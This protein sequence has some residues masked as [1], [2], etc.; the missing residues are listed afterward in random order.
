ME[1]IREFAEQFFRKL[2]CEVIFSGDL[3]TVRN[4]PEKFENFVGKR[5]PFVFSFGEAI[6]GA[7]V[8]R[9]GCFFLNAMA[10]YLQTSSKITLIKLE[11]PLDA[12]KEILSRFTFPNSKIAQINGSF[13]Y[14]TVTR[15][16]FTTKFQHLNEKEF[17]TV[18]LFV[19]DG[20]IF[21]IDLLQMYNFAEGN[22]K[23]IELPDFSKEYEL[24]REVVKERVRGRIEGISKSLNEMLDNEVQR[25]ESHYVVRIKEADDHYD[26]LCEQVKK[27]E[28]SLEKKSGE[29][30]EK[31]IKRIEKLKSE[32]ESYD[33]MNKKAFLDQEKERSIKEEAVKYKLNVGHQLVNTSVIYYPVFTLK[34]SLVSDK[35]KG[36]F[37]TIYDPVQKHMAAVVCPTTN[38][39]IYKVYLDD[40]GVVCSG[41]S[42]VECFESGK[43]YCSSS[44]TVRCNHS[45][46]F[47]HPSNSGVC[48]V[49]KKHF[50]KSYLKE[51]SLSGKVVYMNLLK[52]CPSCGKHSLEKNFVVCPSCGAKVCLKCVFKDF[53]DGRVV[54]LCGV[55]RK[56]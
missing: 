45:G 51:D 7:E 47:I 25:I 21:D 33:L 24:A 40:A 11:V 15:F 4:V 52:F 23:D 43:H 39:K 53:R 56:R 2:N 31:L 19:K 30:R 46:R 17:E 22:K 36:E 14:E 20:R 6:D 32:I 34:V 54:S 48:A 28:E 10:S 27:L 42:L 13:S 12:E 1:N 49:T 50:G 55:C 16:L 44:M 8:L 26:E 3:L 35:A 38:Q 37:V 18:P 41:E 29:A 5:G 9:K